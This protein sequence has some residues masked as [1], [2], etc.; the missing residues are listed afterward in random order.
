MPMKTPILSLMKT[1][2]LILLNS[3]AVQA[4]T[5][6]PIPYS[7][8]PRATLVNTNDDI[9]I[10]ATNAGTGTWTTKRA[11]AAA[12]AAAIQPLI[13]G[14]VSTATVSN[15]VMAILATQGGG[16][17]W[18]DTATG[19]TI[20]SNPV[21]HATFTISPNYDTTSTNSS[22]TSSRTG[23][24]LTLSGIMTASAFRGGI[25]PIMRE[26]AAP[27]PPMG[28]GAVTLNTEATWIGV[29]QYFNTNGLAQA[30]YTTMG[31][32]AGWST[33]RDGNGVLV[34]IPSFS[35]LPGYPDGMPW[36]ASVFKTNGCSL[37]LYLAPASGWIYN[38]L[39]TGN[40][41]AS[42]YA[43]AA[44][45]AQTFVDWGVTF[46]KVDNSFC[47]FG[48]AGER[49]WLETFAVAA[50]N[51]S[52]VAGWTNQQPSLA[53]D[54]SIG[55]NL[56][57]WV[58]GVANVINSSGDPAQPTWAQYLDGSL[59]HPWLTGRGHYQYQQGLITK[60]YAGGGS[61]GV[62]G[63]S[64]TTNDTRGYFAMSCMAAMPLF[65]AVNCI[66][67]PY[68]ATELAIF[69]NADAIAIDQDA[70]CIPGWMIQSNATSQVWVKPLVG[71]DVAV[72]LWN[73][74][75]NAATSISVA[76]SAVPGL[77][78]NTVT[79]LDVFDRQLTGATN[80]LSATV[81][82]NGVNLYRLYSHPAQVA[83]ASTA[84][85]VAGWTYS[86]ANGL[87]AA[88]SRPP[89]N[90]VLTN[91]QV[92]F[93]ADANV[94]PDGAVTNWPDS[95]GNGR[96]ATN[97]G[98]LQPVYHT[99]II[100]SLPA[101]Y[102][103]NNYLV[104]PY[105]GTP[106][107]YTM[108]LV[109]SGTGSG[110]EQLVVSKSYADGTAIS[111]RPGLLWRH[112]AMGESDNLYRTDT[113]LAMCASRASTNATI[114]GP[115]S[116]NNSITC[117]DGAIISSLLTVG[118]GTSDVASGEAFGSLPFTGYIAEVLFYNTLLSDA[119]RNSVL[120]YL[121]NKYNLP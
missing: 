77:T 54:L 100:N 118:A 8:E 81:N 111:W 35:G 20:F 102:F 56:G 90:T 14:G 3:L 94:Y 39:N 55:M 32:D 42:D 27:R 98:A 67:L 10:N 117:I 88:V 97:T 13:G 5:I 63:Y 108:F 82:P 112:Y 23:G 89:T 116:T 71:G 9:I 52:V 119:D 96:A 113:W 47:D 36:L 22:G 43:H 44:Q 51:E 26:S 68:S 86:F 78:S 59:H 101:Y 84:L 73:R 30:G 104:S 25:N 109:A 64:L 83:G 92:W 80:S 115:G 19:N 1:A 17:N 70:L 40:L 107:N 95:S 37:G 33:N 16:S 69:K 6:V 18:T 11:T 76:L 21:T 85:T 72:A 62:W 106:T 24:A 28:Y 38:P 7:Q 65:I 46:A 120:T 34:P 61:Q 2:L 12:V 50:D 60:D 4:A 48:A 79:L 99:N 57:N 110:G 74:N 87:L 103:T 29:A 31:I 45:D 49:V 15:T 121:R 114:Y 91:L 53:I 93:K 75:T 105:A 66:Y 41:P 58:L